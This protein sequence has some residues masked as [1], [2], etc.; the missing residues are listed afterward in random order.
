MVEFQKMN[1]LPNCKPT[2]KLNL[3][4]HLL[5]EKWLHFVMHCSK[6]TSGSVIQNQQEMFQYCFVFHSTIPISRRYTELTASASDRH[7]PN[8]DHHECVTPIHVSRSHLNS[9][10]EICFQNYTSSKA[11]RYQEMKGSHARA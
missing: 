6:F 4:L 5:S 9:A 8:S 3:T 7:T 1:H 2:I 10:S 11:V